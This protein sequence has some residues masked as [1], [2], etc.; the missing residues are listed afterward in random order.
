MQTN[1]NILVYMKIKF[2]MTYFESFRISFN[3]NRFKF[4]LY[5]YGKTFHENLLE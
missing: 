5:D 2:D 4:D 3:Q 1:K